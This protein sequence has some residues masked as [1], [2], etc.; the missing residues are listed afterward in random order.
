M[1]IFDAILAANKP[2]GEIDGTQW[3]IV[4]DNNDP[5][6]LG[7]L[8]VYDQAKGGRYKSDWL[9][10]ALPFTSFTPPVPKVGDLVS[11]GYINGNPHHGC[12]FGV[13]CNQVN[14]AVGSPSDFTIVLGGTKVL[15]KANGEVSVTNA[16]KVTIDATEVILKASGKL[17]LDA[18]VLELKAATTFTIQ[19]PTTTMAAD[20]KLRL[21]N[22]LVAVLG[23]VDSRGDSIVVSGQ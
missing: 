12:Y 11:F 13:V 3:G 10:R 20:G 14:P 19:S 23:G 2:T 9:F 16:P 6:K 18:S 5:L 7:R 17:T 15:I 22:K 4:A 21:A 8:Q 1:Q